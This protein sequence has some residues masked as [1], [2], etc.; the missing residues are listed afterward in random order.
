MTKNEEFKKRVLEASKED[1]QY[2]MDGFCYFVTSKGLHSAASLRIIADELDAL[3]KEW[4][5]KIDQC[6]AELESSL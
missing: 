1:I 4:N 2:D 6:L 3:N 5:E